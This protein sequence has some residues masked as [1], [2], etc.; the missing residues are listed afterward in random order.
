MSFF[1]PI[2]S[3]KILNNVA[4]CCNENEMGP[5]ELLDIALS[6]LAFEQLIVYESLSRETYY[7]DYQYLEDGILVAKALGRYLKGIGYNNDDIFTILLIILKAMI[8]NLLGDCGM[9]LN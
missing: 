8:V 4:D 5:V 9:S 6:L 3:E 7:L 2:V 1:I